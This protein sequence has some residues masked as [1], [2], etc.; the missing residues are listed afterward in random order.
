MSEHDP[1]LMAYSAQRF[2]FT[3]GVGAALIMLV[4]L[5]VLRLVSGVISLPEILA[6]GFLQLLPGAVFSTLLDSLQRSAKPLMYLG[7]TIGIVIVG[8]LLGRWYATRPDWKQAARIVVGVWIVFGLVVYTIA[9]AGPFG[10][11]LQAGP[12]WHGLTLLGLFAIYG[13]A[14]HELFELLRRRAGQADATP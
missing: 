10:S 12:V 13:V 11:R 5:V 2:G 8:G 1:G 6:E 3:A 14:L 9:G 7:I 4:P